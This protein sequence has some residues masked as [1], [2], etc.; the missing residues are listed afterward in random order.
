MRTTTYVGDLAIGPLTLGTLAFGTRIDERQARTLV[1][2]AWDSGVTTFDTA[3][4]YG[5]GASET[6]LGRALKRR[7]H[8]VV[9]AT[10]FGI[11]M[12]GANGEE[13]ARSSPDYVR[14]AVEASLR[15]LGTDYIDLYQWHS[16]DRRTPIEETLGTLDEL[17]CKGL[18]RAVGVSNLT[19]AEIDAACETVN[20]W[21][22]SPVVTAQ[23]E[24]SLYNRSAERDLL[25]V[26]ERR[27]IGVLAYFPLAAG[28]LSG[29]YH[30]ALPAPAGSRLAGSPSRLAAADWRVLERIAELAS[31]FGR[32]VPELALAYLLAQPAVTSVVTGAT[33]VEQVRA[34]ARAVRDALP[35]HL[36]D[37]LRRLPHVDAG[38]TTFAS[39]KLAIRAGQ[40]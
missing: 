6:I 3:D 31:R 17:V 13:S 37:A 19:G 7:R 36:V 11:T 26:C 40:S 38:H 20:R 35:E 5:F 12:N 24:Y 14:R 15:R 2:T 29:R 33:T 8:R 30:R 23:N 9:I 32:S 34:N 16:P 18:V 4:V 1:D 28:L 27:G 10:K 25:P 21:R 22:L 39:R